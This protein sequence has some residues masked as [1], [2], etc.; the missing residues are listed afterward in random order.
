MF[1]FGLLVQLTSGTFIRRDNLFER[2]LLIKEYDGNFV[3][4]PIGFNC[5]CYTNLYR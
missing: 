1:F 5:V 3:V 4:V 2:E